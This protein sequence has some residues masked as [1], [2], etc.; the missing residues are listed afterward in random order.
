VGTKPGQIPGAHGTLLHTT[1][2]AD[3]PCP[4]TLPMANADRTSTSVEAENQ[5]ES[6][7]THCVGL[8][9]A[10]LFRAHP[11]EARPSFSLFCYEGRAPLLALGF[12]TEGRT[13]TALE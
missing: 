7:R 10:R 9:R 2:Q 1:N 5:R 8:L 12:E 4:R 6:P 11:A 13:S 3:E